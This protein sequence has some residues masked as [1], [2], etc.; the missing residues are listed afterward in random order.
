MN[1]GP[2]SPRKVTDSE[3]RQTQPPSNKSDLKSI[4]TKLKDVNIFDGKDQDLKGVKVTSNFFDDTD[5]HDSR[6]REHT[7]HVSEVKLLEKTPN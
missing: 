5:P 1:S 6:I 3:I 2:Q 7:Q 4:L